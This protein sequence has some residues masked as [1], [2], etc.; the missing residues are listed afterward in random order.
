MNFFGAIINLNAYQLKLH[1]NSLPT[2]LKWNKMNSSLCI[3]QHIDVVVSNEPVAKHILIRFGSMLDRQRIQI[4]FFLYFLFFKTLLNVGLKIVFLK[5]YVNM[6]FFLIFDLSFSIWHLE[7]RK[8][9]I[10]M[11]EMDG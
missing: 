9:H 10:Q 4:E 2:S 1:L 11:N 8:A 6:F 7:W 3:L 5:N